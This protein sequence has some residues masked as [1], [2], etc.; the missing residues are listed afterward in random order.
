MVTTK[1]GISND[2]KNQLLWTQTHN[3][4]IG[5]IPYWS[6]SLKCKTP[7]YLDYIGKEEVW[8]DKEQISISQGEF[9]SLEIGYMFFKD[10][11]LSKNNPYIYKDAW[12][13]YGEKDEKGRPIKKPLPAFQQLWQ[14]RISCK[15]IADGEIIDAIKDMKYYDDCQDIVYIFDVL[16]NWNVQLNVPKT[17]RKM[18]YSSRGNYEIEVTNLEDYDRDNDYERIAWKDANYLIQQ[19]KE[20][21]RNYNRVEMLEKKLAL[22]EARIDPDFEKYAK[23]LINAYPHLKLYQALPED[24]WT[25]GP[26]DLR[27]NISKISKMYKG[28]GY[29]SIW[30]TWYVYQVEQMKKELKKLEELIL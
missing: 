26:Q 16:E 5:A 7:I 4:P 6:N 9:A 13:S 23:V 20:W 17:Q 21:H 30:Q 12:I 28:A 19:D 3:I 24:I 11:T 8:E 18:V 22:Y 10:P 2:T 15:I 27:R 14:D 1:R 25:F 29:R